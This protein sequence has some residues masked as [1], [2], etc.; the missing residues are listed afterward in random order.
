MEAAFVKYT[1]EV[2][3]EAERVK[4]LLTAWEAA[5]IEKVKKDLV[6][7]PVPSSVAEIWKK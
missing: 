5:D 6:Y 1:Q 3:A 7:I 4:A 2:H